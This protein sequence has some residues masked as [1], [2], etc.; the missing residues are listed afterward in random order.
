MSEVIKSELD[1]KR[2]DLEK[3]E[4]KYEEKTEELKL[5]EKNDG[6]ILHE[7]IKKAVDNNDVKT[8]KYNFCDCLDGDPNFVK[9][10]KDY[11]YCKSK[12]RLFVTHE[13][14]HNMSLD[15]VDDSY[16]V[17]LK[18]DFMI[19]PSVKRFE[20]MIEAAK[21][22]YKDRIGRIEKNRKDKIAQKQHEL[23]DLKSKC[24]QR[25]IELGNL[26]RRERERLEKIN[27]EKEYD[28]EQSASALLDNNNQD[29]EFYIANPNM[30][31][32]NY[33]HNDNRNKK[34]ADSVSHGQYNGGSGEENEVVRRSERRN[35]TNGY[36]QGCNSINSNINKKAAGNSCGQNKFG[37]PHSYDKR[38]FFKEDGTRCVSERRNPP[39]NDESY[40]SDDDFGYNVGNN[41]G[42]AVGAVV[43]V[44]GAVVGAAFNVFGSAVEEFASFIPGPEPGTSRKPASNPNHGDSFKNK[45]GSNGKNRGGRG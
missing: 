10:R 13:D 31:C 16:W 38:E 37:S 35:H 44:G 6:G 36:S 34:S 28:Q 41:V 12:G 1:L 25:R 22:F 30:Q 7:D 11:E 20:H 8:L 40:Q 27:R 5:L 21:I 4:K 39:T 15:S 2:E 19:N 18:K 26:E 3:L 23:D 24:E 29:Q 42:K 9:S 43:E 32:G 33:A 17:Q 45:K 14:L